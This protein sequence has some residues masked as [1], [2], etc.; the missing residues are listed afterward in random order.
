MKIEILC[1]WYEK[2]ADSIP[3]CLS[4]YFRKQNLSPVEYNYPMTKTIGLLLVF[5]YTICSVG[6]VK[7]GVEFEIFGSQ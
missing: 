4:A 5:Y 1:G 2:Y 7:A 6:L 3:V